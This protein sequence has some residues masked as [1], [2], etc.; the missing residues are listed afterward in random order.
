M[1]TCSQHCGGRCAPPHSATLLFVLPGA[2]LLSAE[3]LLRQA[4]ATPLTVADFDHGGCVGAGSYGSVSVWRHKLTGTAFAVKA[5]DKK[6]LHWKASVHTVIRELA[7]SLAVQSHYV[8]AFDFVFSD[9]RTVY[10]GM[11][12]Y[13]KGTQ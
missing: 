10:A 7:C 11:R 3:E 9:V 6:T 13:W 4:A 1:L 8:A 12:M 2:A 5:M